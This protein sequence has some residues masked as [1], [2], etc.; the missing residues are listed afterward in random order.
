M[1]LDKAKSMTNGYNYKDCRDRV[2]RRHSEYSLDKLISIQKSNKESWGEG[3]EET[4][5]FK[6][7]EKLIK[8]AK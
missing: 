2:A 1:D 7:W 8:Q 6:Y 3:Y 5:V 4:M